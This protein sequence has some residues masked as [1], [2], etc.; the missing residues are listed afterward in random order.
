MTNLMNEI[1]QKIS[2]LIKSSPK[3]DFEK[4]VHALLMSAF[5]KLE[6]VSREEFDAQADLLRISKEK[7]EI[8]QQRQTS[9]ETRIAEL[10]DLLHKSNK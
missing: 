7:L 8:L 4:N 2:D 6:L 1:S 10:E 9:L 3:A 5:T